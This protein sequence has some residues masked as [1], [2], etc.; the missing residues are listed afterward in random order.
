MDKYENEVW[1]PVAGFPRY[2]V[3]DLGRVRSIRIRKDVTGKKVKVRYVLVPCKSPKGIRKDAHTQCKY[4]GYFYVSLYRNGTKYQKYIHTLVCE[5]FL[6]VRPKG[7]TIDHINGDKF[8]NRLMNLQYLSARENTI[9]G[10]V[11]NPSRMTLYKYKLEIPALTDFSYETYS[12]ADLAIR[13][14][15]PKTRIYYRF[16]KFGKF[17]RGGVLIT[18]ERL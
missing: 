12:V 17:E 10:L 7:K 18:R 15:I 2:E 1:K 13:L 5:A 8:D 4:D 14:N 9:K 16:Y 6:G 3:S 11:T